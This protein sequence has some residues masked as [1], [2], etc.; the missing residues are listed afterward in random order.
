MTDTTTR[1]ASRLAA[2]AVALHQVFDSAAHAPDSFELWG[3]IAEEAVRQLDTKTA[4]PLWL[5]VF[6]VYRK[7]RTEARFYPDTGE[8]RIISGPLT[9]ITY[10]DFDRAARAVITHHPFADNNASR[11]AD[12]P[13]WRLRSTA[14]TPDK[15]TNAHHGASS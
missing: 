3:A 6:T 10:P 13:T 14:H 1:N 7:R 8:V 15:C 12:L 11:V 9:G 5:P 2:V 4:P